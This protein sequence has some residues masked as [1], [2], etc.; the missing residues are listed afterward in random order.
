MLSSP[1]QAFVVKNLFVNSRFIHVVNY[2][3]I[4]STMAQSLLVSTLS[5]DNK[6]VVLVVFRIIY[7]FF[8]QIQTVLQILIKFCNISRNFENESSNRKMSNN[9]STARLQRID[10]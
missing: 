9:S 2:W 10:L 3:S 5:V 1:A 7:L 6:N 4:V 8:Y